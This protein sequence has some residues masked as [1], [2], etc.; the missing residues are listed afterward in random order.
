TPG[1]WAWDGL[2]QAGNGTAALGAHL[3]SSPRF[4]TSWAQK[5][6]TYMRSSP[7]LDDD[8]EFVRIA[9]DFAN[10]GYNFNRLVRDVLASPLITFAKPTATE[11]AYGQTFAVNKQVHLCA[12]L[13][14]RLGLHDACGLLS[15]TVVPPALATVDVVASILPQDGYSR[16]ETQPYQANDP[17]LSLLAG[18]ENAC[19]TLA[20]VV[21]DGTAGTYASSNSEAAIASMVHGLMGVDPAD[22]QEPLAILQGHYTKATRGGASPTVA[23]RS[24]FVLGCVSPSTLA[25]GV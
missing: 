8:P 22:D 13:S 9:A 6:C 15:S 14:Q 12:L 24:T 7:C 2:A 1:Q 3:A 16:G 10:S 19:K 5:V 17:T 21:V 18:L 4:A 20:D 11:A 25:N 23:L